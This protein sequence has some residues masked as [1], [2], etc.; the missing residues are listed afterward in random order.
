MKKIFTT[1]MT[2]L[3]FAVFA[4]AQTSGGPDTYGYI[5]RN[6]DDVNGP[7]FNWIDIDALPGTVTVVG[8]A[9]DNI[10]GPF[11][12]SIPF[13]YY[14]YDPATFW[15]G[16]NGYIGFSPTPVASPF[17]IIPSPT[18][19]QNYLAAMTSDLTF[20]DNLG[21][22]IPGVTCKYWQST[23]SLIVTWTDV[24]FWDQVPPSFMGSNTFQIILSIVD[25]SI[26]YQYQ[27]QNGVSFGATQFMSIGIENNSGN[28]GLQY[29]YDQYPLP[30]TAVKF[31]YPAVVTLAINDASTTYV[32]NDGTR[33]LFLS[34]NG[35]AYVSQGE[36]SNTGN[37][38]LAPFNVNSRVINS[39]NAVQ[40]QDTVL[41]N[42]LTPGQSQFIIYPDT[43]VPTV[44]GTYR[45]RN[46]TLLAGDATPS[47]NQKELELQ[48]VDTTLLDIPLAWDNG[49]AST[50]GISW[51]GGGGGIGMHFI[52]PF[53]PCVITKV[54]ALIAADATNVGFSLQVYDDDGPNGAPLTQLDSVNVP[55][56]TFTPGIYFETNT[57]Q[58]IQINSGGFYVAWMM[59][60]DGVVLGEDGI[61]PYSNRCYEVL[62]LA[63]NP[64]S[65]AE[66]RNGEISDPIIHAIIS[67]VVGI[68]EI[69]ADQNQFSE[70]YP[71]PAKYKTMLTYKIKEQ[72]ELSFVVYNIRGK[73]IAEKS[74]GT[75]DAGDGVIELNLQ[76]MDAGVYVCK[77][78]AGNNEYYKK[79]TVIR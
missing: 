39:T 64:N 74:L 14:W 57:S 55:G 43:W 37:Q 76:N 46:N 79:I 16:S 19:I 77:I 70:F 27:S 26:T 7:T 13:H 47:N 4:Q 48:V 20:T 10:K 2:L 42:A 17:P 18:Q 65:W 25:S 61:P 53:Y 29:I 75:Q 22:N 60:G 59:G 71:N 32:G 67:A 69:N 38:S 62:G 3:L 66:Y 51:A 12:M 35:G 45:H 28:I 73:V 52:P 72:S 1:F 31:Y 5:W 44:A 24:P 11:V 36:I 23:D 30:G 6:S 15:I 78:T 56:G 41:S 8:L 21:A 33:G 68:N 50:N 63:S 40:V 9:D 54:G 58:S 34:R 49:T